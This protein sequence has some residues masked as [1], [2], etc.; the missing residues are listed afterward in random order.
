MKVRCAVE[1]DMQ[2][3][4]VIKN[5]SC[6]LVAVKNNWIVLWMIRQLSLRSP[7]ILLKLRRENPISG[8]PVAEAKN[9]PF[10][11]DLIRERHSRL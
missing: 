6:R 1:T 9:S 3:S 11:M 10:A 4:L 7:R 8:V 2:T 5:S